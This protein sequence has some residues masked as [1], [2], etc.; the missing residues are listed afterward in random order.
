MDKL[1][2]YAEKYCDGEVIKSAQGNS[3]YYHFNNGKF[4]LRISDHVGRNSDG[5]ISIIIDKNGYLLHNHNTG[6]IYIETYENIKKI[7]QSLAVFSEVNIKMDI[8]NNDLKNEMNTIKQQYDSVVKKNKQLGDTNTRLNN[9]NV[10]YKSKLKSQQIEID[11]LRKEMRCNPLQT[12]YK[13]FIRYRKA[14]KNKK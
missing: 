8:I 6:A 7:I 13:L 1:H 2:K 11:T 9:E 12:W 5:K 4:I 10:S 3:Y 14:N